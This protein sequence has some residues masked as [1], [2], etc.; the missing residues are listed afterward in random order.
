LDSLSFITHPFLGARLRRRRVRGV[1]LFVPLRVVRL[2]GLLH[3]IR[4]GRPTNPVEKPIGRRAEL[5]GES[6]PQ[7]ATAASVA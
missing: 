5:R 3:L 1:L 6:S 7:V 4:D 2:G